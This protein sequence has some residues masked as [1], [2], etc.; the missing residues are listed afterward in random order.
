MNSQ[1]STT[2]LVHPTKASS[3]NGSVLHDAANHNG[4]NSADDADSVCLGGKLARLPP[5]R[6]AVDQVYSNVFTSMLWATVVIG[7]I[8]RD[9]TVPA[10]H[11][12]VGMG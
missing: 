2:H 3:V 7:T 4:D 6:G 12:D 8:E 5:V 1:H 10:G 9:G 11:D